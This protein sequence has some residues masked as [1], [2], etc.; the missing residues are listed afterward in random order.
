MT[1]SIDEVALLFSLTESA[2]ING[3][4]RGLAKRKNRFKNCIAVTEFVNV[5]TILGAVTNGALVN[6]VATVVTI[7][8]YGSIELIVVITCCKN[9]LGLIF[10]GNVKVIAT[11]LTVFTAGR[12]LINVPVAEGVY[13]T[14]ATLDEFPAILFE[15]VCNLIELGSEPILCPFER[16]FRPEY[17]DL[18]I[19]TTAKRIFT[20]KGHTLGNDD[21]YD[22]NTEVECILTDILNRASKSYR[23]RAGAVCE[24]AATDSGNT[25]TYGNGGCSRA[26]GERSAS[27]LG[28]A[29]GNYDDN[30]LYTEIE[31]IFTN[32]N[33]AVTKLKVSRAG[34]V[35]ECA[36]AYGGNTVAYGN[37]GC[38][39]ASGERS[40]SDL[41]YAIGNYDDNDLYTEI[42][43]LISYI[44][45]SAT[46]GYAFKT[47]ASCKGK[48]AYC[49]NGIGN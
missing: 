32:V 40:A 8:S 11:N 4:T 25:V 23:G 14:C 41:D 39:R 9:D 13:F 48:I 35:C 2:F 28:Y 17:E 45:N 33:Y 19:F 6:I 30:D 22:L 16:Y 42:E 46:E 44:L 5:V 10:T 49:L 26:S 15:E 21:I 37:G 31:R 27:D 43:G 1:E 29:I 24:C 12:F 3:I 34:A 7:G 47:F 38:S 20:H 18:G 36:A